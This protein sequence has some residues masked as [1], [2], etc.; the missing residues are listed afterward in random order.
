MRTALIE[1]EHDGDRDTTH[2]RNMDSFIWPDRDSIYEWLSILNDWGFEHII[3]LG[4]DVFIH[5]DWKEIATMAVEELRFPDVSAL[6]N[7]QFITREVR[8]D[9]VFNDVEFI[10]PVNFHD[11]ITDR[12]YGFEDY[13]DQIQNV[14]HM[15][16]EAQVWQGITEDL[17]G[18]QQI[19]NMC[20]QLRVNWQGHIPPGSTPPQEVVQMAQQYEL[21]VTD[22]ERWLFVHHNHFIPENEF[23]RGR[24]VHGRDEFTGTIRISIDGKLQTVH[25]ESDHHIGVYS[26]SD[27]EKFSMKSGLGH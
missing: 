9:F 6:T 16:Q 10:A 14:L 2:P 7:G 26:R 5:P 20:Q 3:F 17:E 4:D 22:I 19:V 8:R 27:L 21:D 18:I 12:I 23:Y 11:P 24:V 13:N 1:L 15:F 25:E